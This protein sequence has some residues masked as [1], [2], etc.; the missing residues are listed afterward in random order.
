M[1]HQQLCNVQT[2]IL[3]QILSKRLHLC[4]YLA[5]YLSLRPIMAFWAPNLK[6]FASS[7][8]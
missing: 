2:H 1:N 8:P 3:A 6:D 7:P 4:T 5:I